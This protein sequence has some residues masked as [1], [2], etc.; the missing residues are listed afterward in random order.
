M[1]MHLSFKCKKECGS[2]VFL[3]LGPDLSA[4]AS[5]NALNNGQSDPGAFVLGLGMEP[6]KNAE[7]LPRIAH[8]EARSV[9][10]DKIGVRLPM[11]LGS[12]LDPGLGAVSRILESVA[13]KIDPDLFEQRAIRFAGRQSRHFPKH[14]A[15]V[16]LLSQLAHALADKLLAIN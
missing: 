12:H 1:A 5:H 14:F 7:E 15:L 2:F 11:R 3:R 10:S 6:L 16:F 13:Q 8:V 9:I 4:M